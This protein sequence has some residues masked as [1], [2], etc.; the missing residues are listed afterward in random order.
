MKWFDGVIS[1]IIATA[2]GFCAQYCIQERFGIKLSLLEGSM[3][4]ITYYWLVR[5]VF[6]TDK[7]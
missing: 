7:Q 1:F 4:N 6:N 2:C 5:P 3:I